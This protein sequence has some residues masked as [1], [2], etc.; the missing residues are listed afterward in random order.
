MTEQTN[1]EENLTQEEIDSLAAVLYFDIKEFF[2][3]ESGKKLIEK[4][5]N[6]KNINNEKSA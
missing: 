6:E 3:T 2:N 5:S 1:F 4:N